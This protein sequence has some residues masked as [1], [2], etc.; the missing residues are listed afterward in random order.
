MHG[1]AAQPVEA[2]DLR[3]VPSELPAGRVAVVSHLGGFD[4]LGRAWGRLLGEIQGRGLSA[5][6]PFWESYVTEPSPDM[7]PATLRTDLYCP[8]E[9]P[10]NGA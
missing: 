6:T 9:T 10:N 2:G 5:G 8:V 4:G 1:L 3:I 7:D